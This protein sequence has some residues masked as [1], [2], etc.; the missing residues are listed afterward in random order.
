MKDW[1]FPRGVWSG[2]T[3][4]NKHLGF[5]IKALDSWQVKTSAEIAQA[6]IRDTDMIFTD[7]NRANNDFP[8]FDDIRAFCKF[9]EGGIFFFTISAR[10]IHKIM[11]AKAYSE[12]MMDHEFKKGNNVWLTP[13]LIKIGDYEWYTYLREW[14]RQLDGLKVY[15]CEIKLCVGE[16]VWSISINSPRVD[17]IIN[18]S[19]ELLSAITTLDGNE[20]ERL[21]EDHFKL[22]TKDFPRGFW[23]GDTYTN[24]HLGIKFEVDSGWEVDID[25]G[26]AL[27]PIREQDLVVT[28]PWTR[29]FATD[30]GAIWLGE[31]HN[32]GVYIKYERVKE[33]E[34]TT[35]YI[36]NR[37]GEVARA[38]D[39][40]SILL[41]T[42]KIGDFEWSSMVSKVIYNGKEIWNRDFINI[43]N[44][45]AR[46]ITIAYDIEDDTAIEDVLDVI[47]GME[48]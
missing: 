34:T 31:E 26:I 37:A 30:I 13:R 22:K 45:F 47:N 43:H 29:S 7:Q 41:G 8:E 20:T 17:L 5:K 18:Q 6:P 2:D 25:K 42:T 48:I 21:E 28:Y 44:G 24:K 36:K 14:K 32:I 3:Y 33:I 9:G 39:A 23:S 19:N 38:G 35:A 40:P 16:I 12:E 46:Y 1:S 27:A 11:A 10:K 4:T 15:T